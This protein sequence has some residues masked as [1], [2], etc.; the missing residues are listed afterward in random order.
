MRPVVHGAAENLTR[1]GTLRNAIPSSPLH[2]QLIRP[3]VVS[4]FPDPNDWSRTLSPFL[5]WRPKE[6]Q[7]DAGYPLAV[8]DDRRSFFRRNRP[9]RVGYRPGWSPTSESTIVTTLDM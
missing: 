9:T 5:E 8:H 2:L 6:R 4:G 1:A 3:F 7:R